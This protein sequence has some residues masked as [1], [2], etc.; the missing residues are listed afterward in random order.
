MERTRRGGRAGMTTNIIETPR[1]IVTRY[2]SGQEIKY[3][4]NIQ[5]K[6]KWRYIQV[7]REELL[8]IAEVIENE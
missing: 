4:I 8:I 7:S 5:D 6:D 1:I 3:Q 2:V